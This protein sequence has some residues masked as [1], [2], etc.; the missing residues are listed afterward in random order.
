MR[1]CCIIIVK[2]LQ[3]KEQAVH[4]PEY[5]ALTHKFFS[6][7]ISGHLYRGYC[8]LDKE[9]EAKHEYEV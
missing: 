9:D 1:N 4:D 5:V 8:V 3:V 6:K 7:A 2:T